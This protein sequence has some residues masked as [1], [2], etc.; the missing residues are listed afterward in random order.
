MSRPPRNP[1]SWPR[2]MRA[3]KAAA[4]VDEASVETFRRRVGSLYP[5][6]IS[7]SGRGEVWLKDD[8]D[9]AIDRLTGRSAN[10]RDAVDVL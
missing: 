1:G 8:L 3:D 10:V 5:A 9:Q 4:Y 7:V 6:P 2:L